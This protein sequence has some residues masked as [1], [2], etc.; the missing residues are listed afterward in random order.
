MSKSLMTFEKLMVSC[1]EKKMNL[2]I[3]AYQRGYRWK[4][5]EVLQLLEDV[6]GFE[7]GNYF[8][9]LLAVRPDDEHGHLRIID[10]QQ[11]L[12]TLLLVEECLGQRNEMLRFETEARVGSK[13][14]AAYRKEAKET[15]QNWLAGKDDGQKAVFAQKIRNCEFLYF[16]IQ[17]A[18][19]EREFFNRLNTWKIEARD[20][21]LVKCFFL[22]DD[23]EE[24]IQ[25]RA[26][27]WE[28]MERKLSD[29]AFWGMFAN[30]RNIHEDRMG[31][32]LKL[33]PG[34]DLAEEQKYPL[35]EGFRDSGRRKGAQWSEVKECFETLLEWYGKPEW[36]HLIGWYFHRKDSLVSHLDES[37]ITDALHRAEEL[38]GGKWLESQTLYEESNSNLQ[39]YLLLANVAWCSE[40]L[41]IDYDFYRYSTAGTWSIEH[42]HARNQEKLDE[43]EFKS[44]HFK[45][46]DVDSLWLEYSKLDDN[47]SANQFLQE[48]LHEDCGYPSE[49]VD[50]S[51]GN[52]ALLPKNLNSSLNASLFEGK[53]E[54]I[55]SNYALDTEYWVPP[56]TV[57][58]F[59]KEVGEPGDK[60]LP[61]WSTRDREAY[62]RQMT[63][64]VDKYL[65]HMDLIITHTMY[66]RS[67]AEQE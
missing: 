8:M 35:Y 3:P 40:K 25:E 16:P 64:V 24:A 59:A 15:I 28:R 11:R 51:L 41:G 61:Y 57:A 6:D 10:G 27:L 34:I 47:E 49:N 58:I 9:Q 26:L 65:F 12:T 19:S 39:N 60:F 63:A 2:F 13:L 56:L 17:K 21:E 1:A 54:K 38:C 36:R 7:D 44:L 52:L 48:H 5:A 62:V 23:D 43:L 29:N 66:E 46:E 67:M 37:T 31:E 55:L 22:S 14:D 33:V 53:Q 20:S 4:S 30:T 50:H 18:E 45:E 42:V 32:F